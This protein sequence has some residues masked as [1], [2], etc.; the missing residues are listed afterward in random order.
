MAG[1]P[2]HAGVAILL[3][4]SILGFLPYNMHP[5]RVF[6]GDSGAT[7][8]GFILGCITLTSSALLSAGF[9]AMLPML[10]VGVPVADT[11]VSILRRAI[12]PA[13]GRRRATPSTKPTATTSITA[14][15]TWA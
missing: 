13:R 3:A 4:G 7:A 8:I 6:L 14:C 10:L 12:E 5:A 9:A 15:S 11:L 1:R 2:D